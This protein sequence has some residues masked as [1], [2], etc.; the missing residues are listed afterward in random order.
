MRLHVNFS[1][2]LPLFARVVRELQQHHGVTAHSSFLYGRDSLADLRRLGLSTE[3]ARTLTGYLETFDEHAP[4]DLEF[5][6]QK[7]REYGHLYL[8]VAGC[9]FIGSFEHRRALRLLEAGFRLIEGLFDEF[10]PDAVVSDGVACT[11]SYIQYAVAQRRGIPFL[12]VAPARVNNRFYVIRNRQDR[13]ERVDELFAAYKREGLPAAARDDAQAFIDHF[14]GVQLKPQYFLEYA[15]PPRID[16]G[17]LKTLAT[18]VHRR[19][20][21]DRRNYL[22]APLHQALLGRFVRLAKTYVLDPGHFEQPVDGERFVFFPLHFQ[23]EMTTLVLAPYCVDQIAVV[24]NVAK[25]LPIDHRL[26]VKEHK[27]SL[28]RREIGYYRRLKRIPNVRLISPHVDSHDLIRR[29]SAVCVLSSTVG[30]EAILYG[31]PVVTLGD[32][33]YNSYDPVQHVTSYHALPAAF[34]RAV[35]QPHD[36]ELLLKYVAANLFGTY[37]GDAYFTPGGSNPS[38]RDANIARLAAVL[39]AELGLQPSLSPSFPPEHVVHR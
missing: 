21:L 12:T 35:Q 5:L 17:S 38:L 6:R 28:G 15:H 24:E 37:E 30:W 27:A 10:R 26:Y 8:M 23:P 34:A 33:F 29:A 14:R 19:Y 7:E 1:V 39:A 2:V 31:K 4:P 25:T 18:L 11:M 22:L 13:Y 36:P 20:L 32:V 9:R 3:Y 16:L